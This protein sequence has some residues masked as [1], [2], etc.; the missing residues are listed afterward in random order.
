MISMVAALSSPLSF[1]KLTTGKEE[2][3]SLKQIS[4]ELYDNLTD[5]LLAIYRQDTSGK[6]ENKYKR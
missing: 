2:S 6:E 1:S 4:L 5:A 3:I